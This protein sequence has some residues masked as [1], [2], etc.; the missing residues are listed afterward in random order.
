MT[1]T[2]T[3]LATTR[4]DTTPHRRTVTTRRVATVASCSRCGIP[5]QIK[6]GRPISP[7]CRDC[8]SVL[9]HDERAAWAA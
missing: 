8:K 3:R 7:I 6:P 2:I 5:R 1:A 9:T 4:H